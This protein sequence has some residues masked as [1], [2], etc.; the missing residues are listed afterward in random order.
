MTKPKE[1]P[2]EVSVPITSGPRVQSNDDKPFSVTLT[3]Y[4]ETVLKGGT[5]RSKDLYA[6]NSQ[7]RRNQHQSGDE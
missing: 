1:E 6:N 2:K 5:E 7:A 3:S 4:G